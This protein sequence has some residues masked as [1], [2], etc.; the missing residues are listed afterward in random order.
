[1]GKNRVRITV[2]SRE[3]VLQVVVLDKERISIGRAPQNDIVLEDQAISSEHAVIAIVQGDALLEDLDSTNG[4]KVNGQP[5]K[6]HFL[7]DG[8]LIELGRV[9]LYC[10]T[11]SCP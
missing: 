9:T 10:Q 6:K 5:V 7:H 3:R 2:A 4:T 1:M 8:D 11:F